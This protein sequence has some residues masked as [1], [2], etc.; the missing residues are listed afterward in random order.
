VSSKTPFQAT[1]TPPRKRLVFKGFD[2]L[3]L[4][5][6][7]VVI[8]LATIPLGYLGVTLYI[9]ADTLPLAPWQHVAIKN[10]APLMC[11][12]PGLLIVGGSFGH[13]GLMLYRMI[14]RYLETKAPL[15][16]RAGKLI[17]SIEA[18]SAAKAKELRAF[19][20]SIPESQFTEE[21]LGIHYAILVGGLMSLE[22]DADKF[23]RHRSALDTAILDRTPSKPRAYQEGYFQYLDTINVFLSIDREQQELSEQTIEIHYKRCLSQLTGTLMDTLGLSREL[24]QTSIQALVHVI[25]N[26]FSF[27]TIQA[28]LF[29][30]GKPLLPKI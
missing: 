29:L 25:D 21:I 28:A 3:P 26:A 30:D 1:K 24:P 5:P 8:G 17:A 6:K 14:S 20:P 11:L 27:A 19:F 10:I 13:Y 16:K 22:G 2:R 4:F 7:I 9:A 12:L 18:T 15:S 23:F